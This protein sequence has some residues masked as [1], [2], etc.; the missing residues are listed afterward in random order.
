MAARPCSVTPMNAW[1]LEADFMAS[2]ATLTLPS[3]PE[4]NTVREVNGV[5]IGVF[6]LTILEA[7]REGDTG[8]ELTVELGFGGT[9]ADSTPGDEVSNVLGRDGVEKFGPDGDT[10]MGKI[11][12][13]L[14]T[15]AQ[16]L[17]DLERPVEVWV[18]DETFPPDS[19]AWFLFEG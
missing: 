6:A 14:T 15:N 1:G 12:Q 16:T 2:T 8:G 3:V 5:H 7:D 17:V 10:E 18:V 19:C 9:S 4:L 13:E 11:A